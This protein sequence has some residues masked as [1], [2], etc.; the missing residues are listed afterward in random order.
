MKDELVRAEGRLRLINR[1][2]LGCMDWPDVTITLSGEP[3]KADRRWNQGLADPE[4]T[5][6]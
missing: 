2:Q 6:E 1:L 3:V 5:L 4:Y